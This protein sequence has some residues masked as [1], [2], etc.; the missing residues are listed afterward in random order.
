MPI[1]LAIPLAAIAASSLTSVLG[2]I[3]TNK[4]N[5]QI[6]SDTN[7][8]NLQ[9]ARET[10]Q[11]N[12]ENLLISNNFNAQ[13]AQLSRQL[14]S[15]AVQRAQ[16]LSAGINSS[17]AVQ[18]G[19][20]GAAS[21][22]SASAGVTPNLGGY[23][24]QSP[25]NAAS[26]IIGSLP[27]YLSAASDYDISRAQLERM[28]I[29]NKELLMSQRSRLAAQL[30]ESEQKKWLSKQDKIRHAMLVKDLANYDALIER[31]NKQM[32]ANYSNTVANNAMVEQ[33]TKHDAQRM[34]LEQAMHEAQLKHMSV[35]DAASLMSARAN[36]GM[37]HAAV[38]NAAVNS[39]KLYS[40]I[41][42]SISRKELNNA[43]ATLSNSQIS[44]INSL[45]PLEKSLLMYQVNTSNARDASIMRNMILR[46]TGFDTSN[47]GVGLNPSGLLNIR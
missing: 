40:D 27:S 31:Q 4:S 43:N 3:L 10:N 21:S 14:S 2:S 6:S 20:I 18:Y 28:N 7:A 5:K 24:Y 34:Q 9:A 39:A 1:P 36:L 32:D 15:P 17:D 22:A 44:R 46:V 23:Q 29:E 47:L 42:E 26:G 33:S 41:R 35:E 38:K 13:Q 11:Y 8:A 45:S 19:N 25:L 12:R 16:L 30:Y 37:S